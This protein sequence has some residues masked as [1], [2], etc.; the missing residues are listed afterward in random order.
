MQ[1]LKD[2]YEFG[3]NNVEGKTTTRVQAAYA[4]QI[5][6]HIQS[7]ILPSH[8]RC[9]TTTQPTLLLV[10][11]AVQRAVCDYQN[12]KN[13]NMGHVESSVKSW[14]GVEQEFRVNNAQQTQNNH[15]ATHSTEWL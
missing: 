8:H 13:I 4:C 10:M 5:S 3:R 11:P 7:L 14:Q 12:Q 2:V 9:L 6:I 1:Q 15:E